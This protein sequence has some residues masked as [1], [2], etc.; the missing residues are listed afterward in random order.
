MEDNSSH[1]QSIRKPILNFAGIG[2]LSKKF[3]LFLF[4]GLAILI[5]I[6]RYV[7]SYVTNYFA[8]LNPPIDV[9]IVPE[10]SE[11]YANSEFN[12]SLRFTNRATAAMDLYLTYDSTKVAYAKEYGQASGFTQT[13]ENYFLNP[14]VEDVIPTQETGKKNLRLLLVSH[15]GKSK[16]IQINLRF[17]A[18]NTGV[19][20]FSLFNQTKVAGTSDDNTVTHFEIPAGIKTQITV[21]EAQTPGTCICA[22]DGQVT[23]NCNEGY[24]PEC[25][26]NA[27]ECA[28]ITPTHT[29]TPTNQPGVTITNTPTPSNTPIPVSPGGG[30][31]TN[32]PTPT[33]TP[34][35]VSPGGGT[36]TNTPTPSNTPSPTQSQSGTKGDVKVNLKIRLQ[37]V[38]Q[39]PKAEYGTLNTKVVLLSQNKSFRDEK[40]VTFKAENAGIWSGELSAQNV[41]IDNKFFILLKGPKHLMKKICDNEPV[42][43]VEGNYNCTEAKITLKSG[44]QDMNFSKVI[45]LA[46]DIPV[47]DG[48]IDSVDA[49]YIRNNFGISNSAVVTRGDLNYD[50]IVHAQDMVLLLKALEFKYDEK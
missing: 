12:I 34:I 48:I 7:S 37:G 32:T 31:I 18:T 45:I 47:Q 17:K 19:A 21:I 5:G 38:V 9:S 13:P 22:L 42:E 44:A 39:Q 4:I 1:L 35:P 3:L 43:S 26:D 11:V 8:G 30:T 14:V 33:T 20:Q 40:I 24:V 2:R 46:G 28:C 10:K 49:V 25:F 36:I 27:L 15:D 29:P 41:P 23:N 6:I 50:G 16:S